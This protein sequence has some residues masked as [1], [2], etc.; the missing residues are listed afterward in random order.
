MGYQAICGPRSAVRDPRSAICILRSAVCAPFLRA[1]VC[2][3]RSAICVLRSAIR[4]LR[5]AIRDPLSAFPSSL[6]TQAVRP[7][8]GDQGFILFS[9]NLKPQ[10]STLNPDYCGPRS[11]ICDPRSAIR[12]PRR[13]AI[14]DP[15]SAIRD[16]RSAICDLRSA[17]CAPYLN[18]VA[19]VSS[20]NNVFPRLPI[21]STG[22]TTTSMTG[23]RWGFPFTIS[24]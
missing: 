11:A 7:G 13:S 15:R 14:C 2:V 12:D 20:I 18:V 16:P 6:P 8:T 1:A 22:L 5:T 9:F 4:G 3:P 21:N 17:N 10:N 23:T 24:P 19:F